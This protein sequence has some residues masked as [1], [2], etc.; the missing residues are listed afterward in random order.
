ML[1]AGGGGVVIVGRFKPARSEGGVP[2]QSLSVLTVHVVW[3][4]YG[5]CDVRGMEVLTVCEGY[6]RVELGMLGHC[7]VGFHGGRSN[8]P[9]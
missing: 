8:S 1:I 4:V 7:V 2:E 6:P 3:L 9:H 5:G